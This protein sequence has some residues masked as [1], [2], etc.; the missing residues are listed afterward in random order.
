MNSFEDL[1]RS[2]CL[3]WPVDLCEKVAELSSLPFLLQTQDVF[4]STL[5]VSDKSTTAWINTINSS[6]TLTPNLFLK[7][8][9]VLSDIGGE[10]LQRFAK[11]FDSLFPSSEMRYLWNNTEHIHQFGEG[12]KTWTNSKL[13][14]EKSKLL[15][16]Q[17]FNNDM[18]DVCMI[19]LWGS[20][21]I[22]NDKLPKELIE[23]CIIGQFIGNPKEL[24][25]F[26]KR[27]YLFVSRI[28]GGSTSNDLGHLCEEYAKS[29][30]KKKLP[31]AIV[32]EGHSIKE[33]SH[34]DN[35]LTTFD[36][37]AKNKNTGKC[38]AIE[39]SFQVTTN[40]VIERKSGLAKERKHLL[41]SKGHKVAYIID[42]SGN[43]H[44][45]NAI[46]TIFDHSDCTVNLSDEGLSIL[47]A[48]IISS[49]G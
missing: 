41:Y 33:I 18:I 44:R 21:I 29:K 38:V 36:L 16:K 49:I 23:K 12:E 42:G 27:R 30:I 25:E 6:S 3:Y 34:N 19:L 17:E 10:R 15:N 20:A 31:S 22:D 8:L 9:M 37:V 47:S 45:K 28:T 43:F 46:K 35:N 4:L 32:L 26:V 39:I 11:D 40:S 7:H 14:V 13:N 2:A 48:F 5:K 1:E 24:D